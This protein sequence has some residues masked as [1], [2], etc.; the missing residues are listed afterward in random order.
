MMIR[1]SGIV[2]GSLS[3]ILATILATGLAAPSSQAQSLAPRFEVDLSYPK[4][5]PNK[6][7][8]GGIG[9]HCID[10]DDHVLLLNRQDVLDGDLNA[11]RLAPFMIQLDPSGKVVHSWGDRN[12]LEGTVAGFRLGPVSNRL[13][14]CHFDKDNNVW[15]ASSPGGMIQKYTHDGSKLIQQIGKKGAFDTSDGTTK[16]TPL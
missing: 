8:T 16:G 4:P 3:M 14:T 5:L 9:G 10:A 15:I 2:I 7:V 11:G 6:W 13:H 1:M 12:L